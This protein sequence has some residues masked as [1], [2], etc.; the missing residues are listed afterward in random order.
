MKVLRIAALSCLAFTAVSSGAMAQLGGGA[1]YY[2]GFTANSKGC[3]TIRYVF[4]GMSDTPVGYV[5]F[6]DASGISK[7]TG[8]A[9]MKTGKFNLTLKSLDGNGPTGTVE[10]VKDPHTGIVTATLKGPGC[11]NLKLEPMSPTME[12][13]NG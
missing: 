11:S 12:T 9:D 4:R 3:P 5:W 1:G 10:G 13:P 2:Q 8:T 6:S 7:A